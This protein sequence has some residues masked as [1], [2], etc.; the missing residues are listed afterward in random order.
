M[1]Q[2]V[3][4]GGLTISVKDVRVSSATFLCA[5]Y[6]ESGTCLGRW[7]AVSRTGSRWYVLPASRVEC[8][9]AMFGTDAKWWHAVSGADLCGV[10]R[11][12]SGWFSMLRNKMVH[13]PLMS[14]AT[15]SSEPCAACLPDETG[16][17]YIQTGPEGM[18]QC[19][20]A[21]RYVHGAATHTCTA[22]LCYARAMR[23]P[24]LTLHCPGEGG[25]AMCAANAA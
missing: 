10:I 9:N 14:S 17:Y 20:F 15:S 16:T 12:R 23:C 8:R 21:G 13:I 1:L 11:S 5:H 24:G 7:Y 25:Y 6:A 2:K 22:V 19:P 4:V 18:I 3:V